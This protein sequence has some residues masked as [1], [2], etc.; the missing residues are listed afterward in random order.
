MPIGAAEL[1]L[2]AGLEQMLEPPR[3]SPLDFALASAASPGGFAPELLDR[4]PDADAYERHGIENFPESGH[5]WYTDGGL[6]GSQPLG[7]VIAAG[8]PCTAATRMRRACIC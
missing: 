8:R 6:L 1:E 7:R 2:G 3:R 4:R 5:L